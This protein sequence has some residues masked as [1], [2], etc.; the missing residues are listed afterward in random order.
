MSYSG[1]LT[2]FAVK[3]EPVLT[4]SVCV[5]RG[6]IGAWIKNFG[7]EDVEEQR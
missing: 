4:R 7:E 2:A 5:H 6:A 1:R 3:Q